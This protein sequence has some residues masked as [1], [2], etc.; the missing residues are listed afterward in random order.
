MVPDDQMRQSIW[1]RRYMIIFNDLSKLLK[2]VLLG[3]RSK[4]ITS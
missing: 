3:V 4:K 2:I 1:E